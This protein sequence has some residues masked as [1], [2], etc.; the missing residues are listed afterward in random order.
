MKN[1]FYVYIYLDPRKPGQYIYD[2]V[3]LGHEPFYVGKGQGKRSHDHVNKVHYKSVK[4]SHKSNKIKAILRDELQPIIIHIA[5]GLSEK[6][7]LIMEIDII[8]KIGRED[9][10]LGPLCNLTD[11]GDGLTNPSEETKK[12][13][14]EGLIG[15]T[16]W[17]FG[18]IGIYSEETIRK[19][20][21]STSKQMKGIPRTDYEKECISRTHKGKVVS[22]ETRKKSSE[23][24]KGQTAWNKGKKMSEEYC[25]TASLAIS[26]DKHPNWGKKLKPETIEKMRQK[27]YERE[28][29]KREQKIQT[30]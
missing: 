4:N 25:R 28:Q 5:D 11:G 1:V 29:N 13:I 2:N 23:S 21:E 17:N 30:I 24:H 18:K 3:V 10:K 6:D 9:M 22:E 12:K 15:K 7:S 8:R 20:A 19:I 27:A 14:S 16:P 26:G